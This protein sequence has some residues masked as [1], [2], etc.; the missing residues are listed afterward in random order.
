M[1]EKREKRIAYVVLTIIAVIFALPL[2]WIVLASLD[3]NASLAVSMPDLTGENFKEVLTNTAN[4][5]SF[6]NGLLISLGAATIVIILSTLAA[7]AL[8]RYEMKH[9]K[10]FMLSMLFM[11]S[12]PITT[13][14]VPVFKVFVSFGLY[15]NLFGIVL[16][17]A[18]SGMP[19]AIW[20]MKNFMDAVP[21][22]FEEAAWVDGSSR[23]RGII[24]VVLPL[25]LPGIFT[26][27]IYTFS[28]CWGNFFVP[29]I[30]LST[31]EKYPASIMLYQFFGQHSV[32]Y[33][34]LAAYSAIYALPSVIL[35]VIT[36]KWMSQGFSMGGGDKG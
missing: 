13:V 1:R 17:M 12:L 5:R 21:L 18:A 20:M 8:S 28:G 2:A 9:K 25:M 4:L 30:L 36:Q 33:G 22:S 6:L 23:F 19:Y 15:D 32:A 31:S 24:R 3:K 10:M 29:F 16:F 14:M 7:Y 27:G 11:T 34:T 35:Y 26:V